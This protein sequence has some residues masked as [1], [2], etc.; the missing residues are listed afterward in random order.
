MPELSQMKLGSCMKGIKHAATNSQKQSHTRSVS[1]VATA[2]FLG[3][4]GAA[5]FT[6][7]YAQSTTTNIFGHAPAGETITVH[8]TT[9]IH[10]HVVVNAKG[11]Y[12]LPT[13]P[14][15][16]YTVTLEKDGKTVD[17]RANI[18]LSVGRG[19]EIDFACPNDQCAAAAGG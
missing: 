2:A 6:G 3:L 8:S 15:G 19:A 7:A 9:G 11:H 14:L 16:V 5:A 17:T 4:C 18:S 13:L 1:R 10:R 12:S